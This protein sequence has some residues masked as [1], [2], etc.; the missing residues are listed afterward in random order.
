[1]NYEA[2][3][4]E[5]VWEKLSATLDLGV[6][7]PFARKLY[8]FE[9]TPPSNTWDQV[10][11]QLK[12]EANPKQGF[13]IRYHRPLKYTGAAA[14]L[15][16]MAVLS[17]LLISKK[18]ESEV[19]TNMAALPIVPKP[20]GPAKTTTLSGNEKPEIAAHIDP[21]VTRIQKFIQGKKSRRSVSA[22]AYSDMMSSAMEPRNALL[23]YTIPVG[24]D[25]VYNDGDGQ[26]VTL[27]KKLFEA[28]GCYDHNSNCHER[29]K[30]LQQKLAATA[31]NSDFTGVL[32]I[33]KNL[34]ENQ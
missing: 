25:V 29:I 16:T 20:A 33:L 10:S 14:I 30:K 11:A 8:E 17:S 4:D 7:S 27:P 13:F 1:M 21:V 28:M 15:I 24:N 26:A 18:T 2:Q 5:K 34:E 9:T 32:E 31:L 22:I 6:A 3:P 12:K 23:S 19:Q